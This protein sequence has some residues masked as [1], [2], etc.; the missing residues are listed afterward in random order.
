MALQIP[1]SFSFCAFDTFRQILDDGISFKDNIRGDKESMCEENVCAS[2]FNGSSEQQI[3]C[4]DDYA[5]VCRA[6]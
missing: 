2:R 1:F 6:S 5:F 3:G 4:S